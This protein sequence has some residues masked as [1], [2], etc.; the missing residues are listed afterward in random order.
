VPDPGDPTTSTTRRDLPHRRDDHLARLLAAEIAAVREESARVDPKGGNFFQACG[1]LATAGLAVLAL[2]GQ[3]LPA[4]AV[5]AG[6]FT[7]AL[8]LASVVLLALAGRPRLDGDGAG[9]GFVVWAG[10]DAQTILARLS[11]TDDRPEVLA[12]LYLARELAWRSKLLRGK[13]RRIDWAVQLLVAGYL[14][15]GLTVAFIIWDVT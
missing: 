3:R 1:L 12:P 10:L 2:A 7:T 15:A 5:A 8:L 9:F 13:Y 4:P 11:A 14:F 6:A